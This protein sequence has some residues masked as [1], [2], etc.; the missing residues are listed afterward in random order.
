M[1]TGLLPSWKAPY[2]KSP[3]VPFRYILNDKH[4]PDFQKRLLIVVQFVR[5]AQ[6]QEGDIIPVYPWQW[7]P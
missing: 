2:S 3:A 4:Q 5:L 1:H 7:S 6:F